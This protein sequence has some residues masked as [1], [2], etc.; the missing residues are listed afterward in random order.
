MRKK[1]II[2]AMFIVTSIHAGGLFDS[3]ISGIENFLKFYPATVGCLSQ[4]KAYE[5]ALASRSIERFYD[6]EKEHQ[7]KID[8]A[9][10]MLE[11]IVQQENL[12]LTKLNIL[13]VLAQYQAVAEQQ[14]SFLMEQNIQLQSINNEIRAME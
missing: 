11:K 12:N 8:D 10:T 14:K 2:A 5:Y 3:S 7:Q 6:L 1:I 13:D 4:H 9:T